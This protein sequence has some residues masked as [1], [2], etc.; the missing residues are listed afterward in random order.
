[1]HRSRILIAAG[2]VAGLLA[3]PTAAP[4]KRRN[5]SVAA[6]LEA[7]ANVNAG[8]AATA[9]ARR[10]H[11]VARRLLRISRQQLVQ[12]QRITLAGVRDGAM[13]R[14]AATE[15]ARRFSAAAASNSERLERLMHRASGRLEREAAHAMQA[16]VAMEAEVA[17]A[18]AASAQ[19]LPAPDQTQV[20]SGV[21]ELA[22]RQAE[23]T[24]SVLATVNPEVLAARVRRQLEFT[25][26]QGLEAQGRISSALVA[27]YASTQSK[28]SDA[29]AAAS[30][31]VAQVTRDLQAL[32]TGSH[33]AGAVVVTSYAQRVSLGEVS[34]R[35]AARAQADADAL[36]GAHVEAQALTD[37]GI[38]PLR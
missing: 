6:R 23:L 17:V 16:N 1:M 5:I 14:D 33:V 31:R 4:T 30:A 13:D 22:D 24:R 19:G 29:V 3:I 36:A 25:V 37:I 18:L 8:W 38:A 28:A 12:A 26:A 2:A 32:V 7:S 34:A 27:L 9:A 10:S 15:S 35:V 11:R 21:A 20:A